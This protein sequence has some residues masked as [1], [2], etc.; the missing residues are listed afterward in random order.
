MTQPIPHNETQTNVVSI[1]ASGLSDAQRIAI[2]ELCKGSKPCDAAKAAGVTRRALQLWRKKAAFN[3]EL[4]KAQQQTIATRSADMPASKPT[5]DK[6]KIKGPITLERI[7]DEAMKT[8]LER[9]QLGD[10][11]VALEF[12]KARGLLKPPEDTTNE[13]FTVSL[14]DMPKDEAE[15]EELLKKVPPP[16]NLEPTF[17]PGAKPN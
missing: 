1:S 2:T 11:K 10:G 9:I 16:V 6:P 4:T 12:A 8:I 13:T 15:I 3:V 17:K 14:G 5:Q 7:D